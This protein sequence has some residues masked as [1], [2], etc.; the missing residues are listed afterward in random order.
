MR[1][2]R[3]LLLFV[4]TA[5]VAGVLGGVFASKA[6]AIAFTDE[7][8]PPDPVGGVLKICKP[9]AEVGKAYSLQI[10]AREGC[11]PDSVRYGLLG[12]LPPGL[13]MTPSGPGPLISGTPTRAGD[14]RFWL[15]VTDIPAWQGGIFWCSDDHGAE[16]EFQLTVVEG[17][18]IAQRQSTLTPGQLNTPYSLQFTATGGSPT[19]SVSNGALPAGL[20]LNSS[21]GLLS[22]TPTT[23]GDYTF[24]VTATSGSRSDAQTYQLTVVEALKMTSPAAARAEVGVSFQLALQASGGRAPYKWSAA[25]LPAGLTL[26]ATSGEISGTPS[27]ASSTPVK[28][29]VADA[30]GLTSAADVNLSVAPKLA[31]T[32]SALAPARVGVTYSGRLAKSGGVA[33][34]SWSVLDPTKLPLGVRLTKTGRLYGVARRAGTYR[35]RVE[36]TDAL[37]ARST[38]GFVLKVVGKKARR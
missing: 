4:V 7:P 36:V 21:S 13:T 34:V 30:L 17:L 32:K 27:A 31:I 26:N 38:S 29:T 6:S 11:T 35:F 9:N 22:G 37:S 14:Y 1:T 2:I 19:W 25:G 24:K 28:V 12:S 16:R 3:I 10:V 15:T 5:A 23:Q 18:Q 33:P 8:C 20:T